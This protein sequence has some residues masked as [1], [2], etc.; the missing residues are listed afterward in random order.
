MEREEQA[1]KQ[2]EEHENKK[3]QTEINLTQMKDRDK[4]IKKQVVEQQKVSEE[5]KKRQEAIQR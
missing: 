4:Q 2:E 1:K 5:A 3:K